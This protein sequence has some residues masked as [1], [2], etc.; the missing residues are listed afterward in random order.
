MMERAIR[1]DPVDVVFFRD[2]RPFGAGADNYA[3]GMYPPFPSVTAGAI[4]TAAMVEHGAQ[5]AAKSLA[6]K[7]AEVWGAPGSDRFT[8]LL[9]GPVPCLKGET[10][11]PLPADLG[12]TKAEDDDIRIPFYWR[13]TKG[14]PG[15]GPL[16]DEGLLPLWQRR[17]EHGADG[18]FLSRSEMSRYLKGQEP[19]HAIRASALYAMES[20]TGIGLDGSRR[21][22]QEGLLYSARLARPKPESALVIT[23][24]AD[25]N[26]AFPSSGTLRLGGEA[27]M[28]R[29]R[30]FDKEVWPA[31]AMAGDRFMWVL[32][33]PAIFD[34]GWK[35]RGLKKTGNELIYEGNQVRARLV[36]ACIPRMIPIGGFDLANR[37][38]KAIRPAVPAGSVYYFERIEGDPLKNHHA[39]SVSDNRANEGFGI[40]LVGA[41][42]Y[43]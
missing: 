33:T 24:S 4:R 29:Y 11:F 3:A 43:V 25:E 23:I 39:R 14:F 19:A 32:V 20:R 41:W 1:L 13:P 5:L 30:P 7:A 15:A 37:R 9:K 38:H 6:A 34:C 40:V 42:N 16:A 2:A 28:A 10:L 31:G 8:A 21:T 26:A 22:V 12:M 35:P 17:W 36:A 27:R 18:E